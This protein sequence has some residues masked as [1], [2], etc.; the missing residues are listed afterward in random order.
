MSNPLEKKNILLAI[1]GSIAAYK[2][3]ELASRLTQAGVKV[4]VLLTPAAEKFVS[5]LTF[6]SLTGTQCFTDADL[7]GGQGHIVHVQLGRTADMVLIAPASANTIARLAHGIAD[8]LVTITALA[9]RCPLVIV[10]AM[11]AGMFSH[12][13][14]QENVKIL[15]ARGVRFIGPEEGHLA[16]G[17]E[18]KGRMSETSDILREL[19]WM[20][21]RNG[22]LNGKKIVVTAG[23]TAEAIDPVRVISNRSSGK[24]GYAVAQSALDHGADVTLI[25]TPTSLPWP[26]GAKVVRVQTAEE[27]RQAVLEQVPDALALIM[28]AAVADFRPVQQEEEKIKKD[29]GLKTIQLENTAD[30][31]LEVAQK[32]SRL[33]PGLRVIGFAAESQD[34]LRNAQKKLEGKHL[35]MIVVNDITSP[36]AGFGTETNKVSLLFADGSAEELPLMKKSEVADKIMQTLINWLAE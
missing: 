27:M 23:G 29:K 20:F 2:G 26:F 16:S 22:V 34:I 3:S 13:A 12:A 5:A 17:L 21:S 7:W 10:P 19:R 25:T 35:D 15:Q 30:I 14:T 33:N 1:T 4:N 18:G 9:A 8:N 11:D 31:L 24:Q 28:A 36:A 32:K 6:Q